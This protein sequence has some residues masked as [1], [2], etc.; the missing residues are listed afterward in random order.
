MVVNTIH[1][2]SWRYQDISRAP[3]LQSSIAASWCER[4]A[5]LRHSRNG[6]TWLKLVMQR[7]GIWKGRPG[8]YRHTICIYIHTYM[9]ILD[10]LYIYIYIYILYYHHL[11]SKKNPVPK[12]IVLPA[13]ARWCWSGLVWP[14]C[15]GHAF[16]IPGTELSNL[17]V[18]ARSME[19]KQLSHWIALKL[20]PHHRFNPRGSL[21]VDRP[22]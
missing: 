4:G 15:A 16:C 14:L 9:Y 20:E 7:D 13:F 6:I 1:W 12:P 2:F 5:V 8:N 10:A 18:A 3:E 21:Q 11:S 17:A 19:A 22:R